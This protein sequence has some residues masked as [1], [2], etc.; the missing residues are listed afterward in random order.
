MLN[1]HFDTF[2]NF[3]LSL[4]TLDYDSV[5]TCTMSS[6][7]VQRETLGATTDIYDYVNIVKSSCVKQHVPHQSV[8]QCTILRLQGSYPSCKV[9]ALYV[10]L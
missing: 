2:D 10:V 6:F 3:I 8:L 5:Q 7:T 9:M 4:M 1:Q